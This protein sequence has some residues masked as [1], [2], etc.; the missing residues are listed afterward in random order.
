M[1]EMSFF[2]TLK[3]FLEN[4][5]EIYTLRKYRYN[6]HLCL[7]AGVGGC[8]RVCVEQGVV[9]STMLEKYVSKSG[10]ADAGQ[11]FKTA[12]EINK[13]FKGPYYLYHVKVVNPKRVPQFGVGRSK[14]F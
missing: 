7:V 6:D 9:N 14:Y 5:G 8:E 4:N 12:V 10:F 3:T 11:W 13:G 2:P 1:A